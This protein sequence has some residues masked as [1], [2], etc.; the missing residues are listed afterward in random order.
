MPPVETY[1]I[2]GKRLIVKIVLKFVSLAFDTKLQ[3]RRFFVVGSDNIHIFV[4]AGT[5][6][7]WL[8]HWLVDRHQIVDIALQ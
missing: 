6:S 3:C 7:E 2:D 1:V 4:I 8:N 5:V